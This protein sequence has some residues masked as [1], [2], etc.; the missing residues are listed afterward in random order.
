MDDRMTPPER[1]PHYE[2]ACLFVS[3]PDTYTIINGFIQVSDPILKQKLEAKGYDFSIPIY[4]QSTVACLSILD[5]EDVDDTLSHS[6]NLGVFLERIATELFVVASDF[7][8]KVKED[9]AKIER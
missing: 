2:L 7:V 3:L 4:E 6:D 5:E 8:K 9:I 1:K